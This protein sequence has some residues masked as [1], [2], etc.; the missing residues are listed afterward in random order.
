MD[1]EYKFWLVKNASGGAA[2]KMHDSL[3]SAQEEAKRLA[4]A[5]SSGEVFVVAEAVEAYR[6]KPVAVDK[7]RVEY[8]PQ[9]AELRA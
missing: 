1:T 3:E 2:Q 7:L 8:A 5:S 6:K 4:A 9:Q